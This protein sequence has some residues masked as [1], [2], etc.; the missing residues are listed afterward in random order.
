MARSYISSIMPI[1]SKTEGVESIPSYL[2]RLARHN[3]RKP[4]FMIRAYAKTRCGNPKSFA[5]Y[6]TR[7]SAAELSLIF[8]PQYAKKM[9]DLIEFYTGKKDIF[10]IYSVDMALLLDV[11]ERNSPDTYKWCSCCLAAQRIKYFPLHWQFS[12]IT[13]CHIHKT[14]LSK[15]CPC[16]KKKP[17]LL[18]LSSVVGYC[19]HC[20]ADLRLATN[21]ASTSENELAASEKIMRM[22]SGDYC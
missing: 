4:D 7:S 2:N 9:V 3:N 22:L 11:L 13:T 16:C 5:K 14:T 1:T 6:Y 18:K 21:Q 10:E 15:F 19:H 8:D 17:Q 12:E 20:G